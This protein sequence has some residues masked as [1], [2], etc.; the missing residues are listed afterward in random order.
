MKNVT[1]RNRS[2]GRDE[3]GVVLAAVIFSLAALLI[4]SAGALLIGSGD[5]QAT[6][7]YRG[8]SQATFVAESALT[9]ALQDVN[10]VGVIS[11]ENEVVDGWSNFLGS[12]PRDFGVGGWQ[13]AVQP[14]ADP[15]NPT[16][17]GWF[18]ASAAGPEGVRATAVASVARSNIPG[19]APGAIYL[20]NDNPTDA[21]FQGNNFLVDG[22]DHNL[23]GTPGTEPAVPGIATR[24][25]TNTQQTIGALGGAQLDN[26][27]GLGFQAGPPPVPA[28]QTAPSGASVGQLNAL[29]DSLLAQ[30]HNAFN[31]TQINNSNNATFAGC[32]LGCPSDPKISY[33]TANELKIRGNGNIEGYGVMIIDGDLTIQG[34]LDFYG[35][36]LVR[37]ET[38]INED[39]EL[40]ITG[41]ATVY[42]SLWTANLN[43]VVGGSAL[44]NYSS[45]ALAFADQVIPNGGF[46]TPLNVVALVDCSQVPGGLHG[47]P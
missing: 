42:G 1:K 12:A 15:A 26:V 14:V 2:N 37:G 47:C 34:T 17:Q 32:A 38:A 19:T 25:D 4:G 44:V 3:R 11:Y 36:I 35:L 16:Q 24:N 31:T 10:A 20:A 30:P 46:P 39:S 23:D 9:H 27:E 41:N 21:T 13:Y 33:F 5:I 6:R 28:I 29:I 43:L 18:V 7:N 8:A 22:N 40:G 45:Q